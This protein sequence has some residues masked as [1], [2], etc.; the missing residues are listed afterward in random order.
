MAFQIDDSRPIFMQIADKIEDDIIEARLPEETQVPSTN[1]FAA[2]YQIN[3][4]TAAKGVNLLV[5]QGILYKKR[6]IGMF[7]ASGA[8][9]LLMEKRKTEF[10]EQY[11]VAMVKEAA[12]LGITKDQLSE[13][14][15]RGEQD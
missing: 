10:Y 6:G 7:V 11:V 5:D 12:K 8:R 1:Q 3:P 14:I 9:E 4:A 13:M 15:R 2:F